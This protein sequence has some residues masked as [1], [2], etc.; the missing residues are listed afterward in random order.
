[1][2]PLFNSHKSVQKLFYNLL[3]M[4]S[5]LK[6]GFKDIYQLEKEHLKGVVNVKEYFLKLFLW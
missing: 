1:M 2:N 4:F 6:I 5:N 3:I